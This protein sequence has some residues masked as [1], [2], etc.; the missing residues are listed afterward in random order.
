[1]NCSKY[2]IDVEDIYLKL[3]PYFWKVVPET[4]AER[5]K[6]IAYLEVLAE[7]LE[8]TQSSLFDLCVALK[9]FL[10]VTGQHL[11]LEN[12][13]NNV[14]DNLLRRIYITENDAGAPES[15]FLEGETD[16]NNKVWY[17]QGES[18]PTQKNWFLQ[19]EIIGQ[20]FN[21][22]IHIPVLVVF[23]ETLLRGLL[24]NYVIAGKTYTILT[25]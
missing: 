25:F 6:W 12:Y 7:S 4:G 9:D 19:S 8:N 15:W 13:L 18:D 16:P 20:T 2:N 3:V 11:S 23:D 24:D 10:D 5:T 17:L 14:Y 21:F 22:T 1:M